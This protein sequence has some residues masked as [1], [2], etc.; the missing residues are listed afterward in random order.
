VAIGAAGEIH[1]AAG[2]QVVLEAD[3][4]LTLKVGPSF[5]DINP[6]GIFLVGPQVRI[7]RGGRPASGQGAAPQAPRTARAS[8]DG[9]GGVPVRVALP[10]RPPATEAAQASSVRFAAQAG[11]PFVGVCGACAP[12]CGPAGACATG[13]APAAAAPPFGP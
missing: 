11:M 10:H 4:R 1:L 13:A 5:I 6:A 3:A 9:E 2:V 8:T 7:N 12:C